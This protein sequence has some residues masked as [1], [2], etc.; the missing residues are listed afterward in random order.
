MGE[1]SEIVLASQRVSAD[2]VLAQGFTF[3]YPELRGALEVTVR[4]RVA[5]FGAGLTG[6]EQHNPVGLWLTL[7]SGFHR[8]GNAT[9]SGTP[10]P[11]PAVH[12][13]PE[14]LSAAMVSTASARRRGSLGDTQAVLLADFDRGL[15]ESGPGV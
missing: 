11:L 3:E 6:R 4:G 12:P 1:M 14:R 8:R 10:L 7:A 5:L 13:L 15:G 9:L 2:K